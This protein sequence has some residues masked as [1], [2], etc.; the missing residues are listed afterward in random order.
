MIVELIAFS[1]FIV[2]FFILLFHNYMLKRKREKLLSIIVQLEIDKRI[3]SQKLVEA[4]LQV[5]SQAS[6]ERAEGFLR[7]VSESRDWAFK[8]IEDVQLAIGQFSSRINPELDYLKTQEFLVGPSHASSFNKISEA[9]AELL[10]VMPTD[11]DK[12]NQSRD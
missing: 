3:L 8:Y 5:Q 7:F 12:K 10:K 6:A 9:Y 11:S 1:I 2:L 4:L